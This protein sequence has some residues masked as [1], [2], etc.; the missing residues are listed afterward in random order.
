MFIASPKLPDMKGSV[1]E[2]STNRKKTKIVTA[3]NYNALFLKILQNIR[4]SEYIAGALAGPWKLPMQMKTP[5]TK[6]HDK[7][8][9]LSLS[10]CEPMCAFFIRGRLDYVCRHTWGE[11]GRIKDIWKSEL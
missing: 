7:S 2:V 9:S 4:L 3:Y 10:V 6:L 8:S 11:R 1:M 5:K